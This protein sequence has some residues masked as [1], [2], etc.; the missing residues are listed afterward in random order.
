MHL[1]DANARRQLV[2]EHVDELAR[3]VRRAAKASAHELRRSEKAERANLASLL[4]R[5]RRRLPARAAAQRP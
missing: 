3:D 4:N 5:L 1:Y 2:R